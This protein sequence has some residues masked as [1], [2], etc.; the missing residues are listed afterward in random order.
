M[1]EPTQSPPL[2]Y[3][4]MGSVIPLISSTD[5]MFSY[6]KLSQHKHKRREEHA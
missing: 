3:L 6:M 2:P 1:C 4:G 5:A